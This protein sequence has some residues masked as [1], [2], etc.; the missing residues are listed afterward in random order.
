M[1]TAALC[2]QPEFCK[3]ELGI[4]PDYRKDDLFAK[5]LA[6]INLRVVDGDAFVNATGGAAAGYYLLSSNA[7]HLKLYWLQAARPMSLDRC[8]ILVPGR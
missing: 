3:N 7:V 5:S 2:L 6:A 4:K 1:S 8:A